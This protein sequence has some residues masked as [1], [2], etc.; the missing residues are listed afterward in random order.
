LIVFEKWT[1]TKNLTEN[2][3]DPDADAGV[4]TIARLFFFEVKL[5]TVMKSAQMTGYVIAKYKKKASRNISAY[6]H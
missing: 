5:K 4:T 3:A 2:I 1:L 6:H